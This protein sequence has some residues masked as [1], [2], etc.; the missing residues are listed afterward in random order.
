MPKLNPDY[1]PDWEKRFDRAQGK[2]AV[3]KSAADLTA[4]QRSFLGPVSDD[5]R[6]P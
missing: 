6:N 2:A 5:G 4:M 3:T 1:D